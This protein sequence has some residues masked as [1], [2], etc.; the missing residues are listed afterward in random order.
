MAG[1]AKWD[2]WSAASQKY[3][4]R[5]EAAE[6]RYLVIAMDLGWK[7]GTLVSGPPEPQT[8]MD[9]SAEGSSE[10]I[11]NSDTS[12]SSASGGGMG[13]SVSA[14]APPPLDEQDAKTLHGLAIS[15]N[16]AGLAAHLNAHP[17]ISVDEFDE[18]VRPWCPCIYDCLTGWM[19][20]GYTPLHLAC[21]RGNSVAVELLLSRGAD[22]SLQVS[23]VV[24]ALVKCS[25]YIFLGS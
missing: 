23:Y 2:A 3:G 5:V 16:A 17:D 6:Q 24:F 11:E 22:R 4:T 21:D 13:L 18:H 1:R 19:L 8:S 7:E 14:M 15:N 25:S 9:T 10:D 12:P 20:Q